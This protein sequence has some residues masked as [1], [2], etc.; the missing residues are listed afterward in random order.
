M[1]QS[2]DEFMLAIDV[3]TIRGA[4]FVSDCLLHI[5][6]GCLLKPCKP[7]ALVIYTH[8]H[9]KVDNNR[10]RLKVGVARQRHL[11]QNPDD[12]SVIFCV[13]NRYARH[14]PAPWLVW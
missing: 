10:G 13:A 6:K 3:K 2:L 4:N 5:S 11:D 14:G 8:W 7:R 1:G 12:G 9:P